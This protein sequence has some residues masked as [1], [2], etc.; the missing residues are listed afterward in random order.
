MSRYV[1]SKYNFRMIKSL[2]Y[3]IVSTINIFI[4]NFLINY[5]PKLTRRLLEKRHILSNY[6]YHFEN[7]NNYWIFNIFISFK[8]R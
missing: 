6:S 3:K 8:F 5:M 7:D 1:K 4:A 2:I